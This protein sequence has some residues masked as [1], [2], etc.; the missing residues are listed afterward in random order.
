MIDSILCLWKEFNESLKVN[1][2]KEYYLT[3]EDKLNLTE[4]PKFLSPFRDLTELSVQ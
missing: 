4:L 1:G 2:D 3:E